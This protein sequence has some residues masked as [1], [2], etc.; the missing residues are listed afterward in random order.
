MFLLSIYTDSV[1]VK[2]LVAEQTKNFK[3]DDVYL[4][5]QK[6]GLDPESIEE[7]IRERHATKGR[8]AALAVYAE[9]ERRTSFI[10]DRFVEKVTDAL[11]EIQNHNKPC[12]K[13]GIIIMNNI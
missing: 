5:G 12:N 4:F 13:E 6:F 9:I 3:L 11:Q 2:D 1:S 10:D 8:Q 7:V